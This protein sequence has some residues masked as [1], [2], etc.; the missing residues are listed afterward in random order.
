MKVQCTEC[1]ATYNIS[2]DK[3]PDDGAKT[4]C[5]K[6][7]STILIMKPTHDSPHSPL[8]QSVQNEISDN[9]QAKENNKKNSKLTIARILVFGFGLIVLALIFQHT[10]GAQIRY[11]RISEINEMNQQTPAKKA[12]KKNDAAKAVVAKADEEVSPF[13]HREEIVEALL[14]KSK[15]INSQLPLMLNEET[16]LDATITANN[17]LFFQ[18]TLVNYKSNELYKDD[19]KSLAETIAKYNICLNQDF[20][21]FLQEGVKISSLYFGK[22]GI[23][24]AKI[25]IDSKFCEN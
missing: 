6:C 23:L 24:I 1:E 20:K 10:I 4:K 13:K 5:P 12:S 11:S 21:K 9:K 18:Y 7:S 2:D 22:D 19:V 25:T 16:R 14:K 17:H 15:R 8:Q 3:I